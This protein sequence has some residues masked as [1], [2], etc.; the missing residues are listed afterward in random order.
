MVGVV[1]VDLHDEVVEW[2]ASLTDAEWERAVVIV[3][4]L[5]ESG[6]AGEDALVPHPGR[7]TRRA[8]VQPRSDRSAHQY[9]FT[10]TAGSS[11]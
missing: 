10:H 5:A 7:W 2:L 11:C 3:D 1:E 8:V 6:V 4:R 9:R